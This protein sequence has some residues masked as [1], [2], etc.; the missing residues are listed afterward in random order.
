MI[1]VQAEIYSTHVKITTEYVNM[2]WSSELCDRAVKSGSTANG[3]T[4]LFYSSEDVTWRFSRWSCWLFRSSQMWLSV[5][6]WVYRDVSYSLLYIFCCC[7]F[8][9]CCA[10]SNEILRV[11][12][13]ANAATPHLLFRTSPVTISVGKQ[14][15]LRPF[16]AFLRSPYKYLTSS[17]SC[18]VTIFPSTFFYIH[19]CLVNL[20]LYV[21]PFEWLPLLFYTPWIIKKVLWKNLDL[22]GTEINIKSPAVTLCTNKFNIQ[23]SYVL[24]TQ[25]AFVL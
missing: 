9:C 7:S 23:K 17:P 15:I 14:I 5:R 16:V 20:Q 2:P 6:G 25:C 18:A 11:S 12:K 22:V 21:I 3:Y 4:G 19:R 13:L 8:P 1:W 10:S 24:P